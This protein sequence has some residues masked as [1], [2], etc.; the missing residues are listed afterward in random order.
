[1]K[2]LGKIAFYI[3]FALGAVRLFTGLSNLWPLLYCSSDKLPVDK[4]VVLR[5]YYRF[6]TV[7]AVPMNSNQV[8]SLILSGL[9]MIG[10]AFYI[11]KKVD[12]I[13]AN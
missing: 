7:E 13:P 2:T 6:D 12:T 8:I 11:R 5:R 4:N 10:L 1:M 9:L 3:L